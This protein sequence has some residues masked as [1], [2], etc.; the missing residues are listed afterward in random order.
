MQRRNNDGTR[1]L[2]R[3]WKDVADPYGEDIRPRVSDKREN[4]S[5]RRPSR[6]TI[7]RAVRTGAFG[8]RR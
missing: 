5:R 6:E 8:P 3:N 2:G 4:L 7:R 1:I